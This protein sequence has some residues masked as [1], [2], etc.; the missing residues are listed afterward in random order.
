LEWM[1]NNRAYLGLSTAHEGVPMR[2]SGKKRWY[3]KPTIISD[4]RLTYF[5]TKV[6]YVFTPALV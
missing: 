3:R 1:K 6:V 2:K 4:C 5:L